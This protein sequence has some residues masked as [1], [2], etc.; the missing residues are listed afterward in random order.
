MFIV[1]NNDKIPGIS[2]RQLSPKLIIFLD[3]KKSE[4]IT[5]MN[6]YSARLQAMDI[7]KQEMTCKIGPYRVFENILYN[8]DEDYCVEIRH[9]LPVKWRSH[10]D[11]IDY[12]LK[13]TQYEYQLA[14]I[15]P[16]MMV[17]EFQINDYNLVVVSSSLIQCF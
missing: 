15:L 1:C 10:P 9:D 16:G 14:E 3:K 8:E 11:I 6:K 5:R 4:L 7:F 17:S 2:I 13:E 12:V